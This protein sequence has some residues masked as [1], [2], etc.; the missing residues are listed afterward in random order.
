[1]FDV[2][3]TASPELTKANARKKAKAQAAQPVVTLPQVATETD[4]GIEKIDGIEAEM[5]FQEM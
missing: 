5:D 2:E 4:L 1:M 3:Q